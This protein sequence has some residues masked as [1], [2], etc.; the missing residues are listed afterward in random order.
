MTGKSLL[1]QQVQTGQ[2]TVPSVSGTFKESGAVSFNLAS[3]HERLPKESV[4]PRSVNFD[5][6]EGENSGLDEEKEEEEYAFKVTF[7]P[8]SGSLLYLGPSIM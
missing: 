6:E 2:F 1:K 5:C 4:E 7:N 3:V 8:E